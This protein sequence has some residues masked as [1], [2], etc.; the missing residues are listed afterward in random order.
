MLETESTLS[1]IIEGTHDLIAALDLNMNFTAFNNAYETKFQQ[2]FHRKLELGMNLEEALGAAPGR[3]E[4]VQAWHRALGGE[5]FT[6]TQEWGDGNFYETT[7]NATESPQHKRIGASL[8]MRDVTQRHLEEEILKEA[9]EKLI[10]GVKELKN[11]YHEMALLNEM[12]EVLQ[13][14]IT[15]EKLMRRLKPIAKKFYLTMKAFYISCILRAII[16]KLPRC[17]ERLRRKS[18]FLHPNNV[19]HYVAINYIKWIAW[20]KISSAGM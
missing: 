2:V 8:I 18:A 15:S 11:S 20:I 12:S 4:L 14:C 7:F 10:S 13:S 1:V 3:K 9:N 17:G 5:E 16:W 19:G 6:I